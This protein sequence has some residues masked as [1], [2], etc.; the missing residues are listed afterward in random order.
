MADK[1]LK[2]LGDRVLVKEYK[3]KEEKRTTSGIIIP[4]TVSSEDVKMGKVVAV[5]P[6]LYT[7]N[8]SLIPMS[9]K[10]G[11][12]VELIGNDTNRRLGKSHKIVDVSET[13]KDIL[14]KMLKSNGFDYYPLRAFKS[15]PA[16][17]K[18]LQTSYSVKGTL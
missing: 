5:G 9:V 18:K 12:E 10:V 7:Q 6:G 15:R 16:G 8:G 4:E 13:D 14:L 11:D 1:K 17:N 2:P 3:N